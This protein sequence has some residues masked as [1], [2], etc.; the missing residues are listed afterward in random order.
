MR[1][2][3]RCSA[4]RVGDFRPGDLPVQTSL[5]WTYVVDGDVIPHS[6][7][8]CD[9]VARTVAEMR[10]RLAPPPFLQAYYYRLAGRVLVHE[11]LHALLATTEHDLAD[12]TRSPL[13]VTDL[14]SAPKL[15]PGQIAALRRIGRAK[16]GISIA[17]TATAVP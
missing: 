7:V 3:G 13:Q 4:G 8:D 16:A 9:A 11:M 2:A 17:R 12:F 10:G 14:L 6:V 5:G 1:L 15:R